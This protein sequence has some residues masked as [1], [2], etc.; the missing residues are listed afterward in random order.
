VL[1]HCESHLYV[2]KYELSNI[3][4]TNC[5]ALAAVLL[6]TLIKNFR[7][8]SSAEAGI[9][10]KFWAKMILLFL[11]LFFWKKCC[12]ILP[13]ICYEI[14]HEMV[15]SQAKTYNISTDRNCIN[16]SLY[17]NFILCWSINALNGGSV[18]CF[19]FACSFC[20]SFVSYF[21]CHFIQVKSLILYS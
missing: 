12:I 6:I 1:V 15:K 21:K 4:F 20:C 8:C 5:A 14:D 3:H 10:L 11:K 9:V 19:T 17:N 7:L 2:N 16:R 13:F 18:S